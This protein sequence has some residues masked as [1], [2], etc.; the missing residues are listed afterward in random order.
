MPGCRIRGTAA[1]LL[2][3]GKPGVRQEEREGKP[4]VRIGWY[5]YYCRDARR[6]GREVAAQISRQC[7]GGRESVAAARFLEVFFLYWS[8]ETT[9]GEEDGLV[10]RP[11]QGWRHWSIWLVENV[12]GTPLHGLQLFNRSTREKPYPSKGGP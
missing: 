5:S 10:W 4:R 6:R 8:L 3:S 9:G 11:S 1:R 2:D 7:A 12:N